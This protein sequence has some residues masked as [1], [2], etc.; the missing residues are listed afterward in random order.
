MLQPNLCLRVG[1]L[2]L[3][4]AEGTFAACTGSIGQPACYP[5]QLETQLHN[6]H[7]E[8]QLHMHVPHTAACRVPRPWD[9][10][11]IYSQPSWCL[12]GWLGC[13]WLSW[14]HSCS[15]HT[16]RRTTCTLPR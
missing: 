12:K 15:L 6:A 14:K 3:A 10:K 2:I 4:P 11:T 13:T 9:K 7:A 8:T 1:E 5:V 16:P